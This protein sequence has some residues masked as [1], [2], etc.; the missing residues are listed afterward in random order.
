MQVEQVVVIA[1]GLD[2]LLTLLSP[3]Y[4]GAAFF[5]LD[6]P[7]TQRVKKSALTTLGSSPNFTLIPID[8]TKESIV[9]ALRG[10]PFSTDKATLFIAEGITMYLDEREIVRFFQQIRSSTRNAK[11]QFLFT[12][13]N[14]QSSGSIQFESATRLADS[15][16]WLKKEVF[17]WGIGSTDLP[18]FLSAAGYHFIRDF[19]ADYFVRQ[20]LPD[21]KLVLAKGEYICLARVEC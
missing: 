17:K 10:S 8:L 6:H 3:Q 14:K 18:G 9:E 16:L 13:M 11:S 15:W 4:R 5:E 12:Y 2:P 1:G 19:D 21:K 7:A 20:Y